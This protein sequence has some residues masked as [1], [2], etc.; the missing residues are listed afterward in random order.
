MRVKLNKAVKMFFGNSS[1]EMVYFEAVAN[2]LDAGANIIDINISICDFNQPNTLAISIEDNG[3]GFTDERFHKFS[4][5]FDVDEPTHKG[6]GR[7]VYICYFEKVSVC[8]YYGNDKIR[9]FEFSESFDADSHI[10]TN[11]TEHKNGSILTMT[12]YIPTRLKQYAY[13]DPQFVKK[14]IMDK[15][16]SRLFKMKLSGNSLRINITLNTKEA[17]KQATLAVD[18]IPNF[19]IYPMEGRKLDLFSKVELY[20]HIEEVGPFDNNVITAISVD[21]RTYPLDII[22]KENI[23][24]GYNMIFLLYS[25]YFNGK[26]DA[27]RETLTTTEMDYVKIFFRNVII[28]IIDNNLPEVSRRNKENTRRLINLFPHLNG[29]IEKENIGYAATDDVLKKAQE[30]FLRA[31]R[32]IL[33]ASHLT[34]EQYNKSMDLASRTLTEY[35]L[36]RQ[37]VI[38]KLKST[39]DRDKESVI[40][41]LIVPMHETFDKDKLTEDLYRNNIWI[42]DDKYMTYDT[43]LSDQDMTELIKVITE[44]EEIDKDDDRPDIAIVFSDDPKEDVDKKVNVVIVELKKKG[45]PIENNSIVEIQLEKRA[46]KLAKF[47]KNKIQQ[48]WFYGVVEFNDEYEM[49]LESEYYKLYSNGRV[50]YK[51][52]DV[53]IQMD[54][55]ETVPAGIFIMDYDAVVQDAEARNST[56]LNIIKSKFA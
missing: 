44:G 6:L 19:V 41:N 36:F 32:E 38:N 22:A 37:N 31:Q 21:D 29:Y 9:T 39:E 35:I 10:S 23:P 26:V 24:M 25:D 3:V 12:G 56:F 49:H 45:L 2:A 43:I 34:E 11:N 13:V 46:R 14:R 27:T 51:P 4:N 5:L 33:C 42:L 20:Y 30:K 16:Y 18:D 53:V 17:T 8:S 40:H 15:F 50:Y 28:S 55:K 54:P 7:L 48:I 52:K 1:L 47:Y